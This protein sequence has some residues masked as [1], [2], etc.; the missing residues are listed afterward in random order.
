V[1]EDG[2]QS[3]DFVHVTDVA[4]ANVA[5]LERL[6]NGTAGTDSHLPGP[7]PGHLRAYNVGSGAAHTVGEMARALA[8]AHGGPAPVVTGEFRLGDVRHI[9]ASSARIATELGWR[10]TVLFETG[11]REFAYA[12]LRGVPA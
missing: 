4:R 1:F 8:D 12:P 10:A 2:G 5:A 11:M 3:R 6:G 9:T 7:A